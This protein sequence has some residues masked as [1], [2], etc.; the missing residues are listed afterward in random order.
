MSAPCPQ[1]EPVRPPDESQPDAAPRELPVSVEAVLRELVAGHMDVADACR[2]LSAYNIRRVDDIANLD[3]KRAYRTG[4]PEAI[5]ARGKEPADVL[6]FAREMVQANDYVLVTK[7]EDFSG[8]QE[9]AF[10]GCE[11]EANLKAHTI[12]VKR[13]GFAFP[14]Q[15]V[16]GVLAAGTAD[17]AVAEEA[18]VTAQVMGCEVIKHYDVGVAGVHRLY[19]PLAH[20]V[21]AG[22]AAIIAVAGMDAVLPVLISSQVPLPV[23]GV[24]TSVGYGLGRDGVAGLMTMLQS[25]SPGLVVVNIDNGFGAGVFAALIARRAR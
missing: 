1:E 11:I 7:V 16:I 3:I 6:R 21:E 12:V 20:M 15:G 9:T 23:I 25:C 5:L 2:R 22:V 4:A 13:R 17:V 19:R 10:P 8:F 14:R 18:V 24:P